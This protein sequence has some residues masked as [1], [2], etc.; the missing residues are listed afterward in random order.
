MMAQWQSCKTQ[1]KD[2][3]L[4]FR[5]G[6][7]YEAFYDDAKLISKQLGLT[8]T[9][10]QGVPM[11]GVPF[12]AHEQYVDK[13]I[14][15]GYKIAIAEQTEDPK[16]AKG[17][18]KREISR[19]CSPGTIVNSQLLNEK[20]NNYIAAISQIGS[21][22]GLAFLDLTTGD[23]RA[24]EL[25]QEAALIDELHRLR[26]AEFI[27]SRKFKERH[28]HFFQELSFTF[29]FLL[30]E[31]EE[32]QFD[33][34][35]A[36]Q[37]LL[38]HFQVSSLDGFGMKGLNAAITAAGSLLTYLKDD[39]SL[40]LNHIT[41]IQNEALSQFMAID[42]STMRNLELTESLSD[43]SSNN[44]LLDLIDHTATPM[45][46]RLI[47]QWLKHP[48]LNLSEIE[49]RQ[50]AVA[51][52]IVHPDAVQRVHQMLDRVRDLE[53]L[54]A[55]VVARYASPRDL[56]T[57]GHSLTVI[58][59]IRQ[60]L[61]NLPS[62]LIQSDLSYLHDVSAIAQEIGSSLND[63]PPLRISD[64]DIFRSG[65]YP[66]LD[67]LRGLSKDGVDWMARYQ[68]ELRERTGIKTLKVGYTK[69]FGYYIEVS[70]AKGEGIPE[71]FQRSQTLVNAER[72][73]TE[74]LKQ[75]EHQVLT[76]DERSKALE[77]SLFEELRSKTARESDS[78]LTIAK[79]LARI[80]ALLSLALAARE[81]RFNRPLVDE[82][83]LLE[84]TN[85]RHPVLERAIGASHFIPNDTH[86]DTPSQQ[87][88]LLTGPNMA[89]KS[90]YIRQ[91]ALIAILAQMGS[92]VP[93][94]SA[95]IGLIDRLFSRIGASDDLARGQST[96]MVEMSETA[97]ILHNAT[98][99]SLI[100]L[101]EIGRG[102]STYDGISIAWAVAEFLLT[103]TGK[104]AKTLFATH[105]W[106]LTRLETEHQGA[107]N[108]HV[109]VQETGNGIVF[110]RKIIPGGTDRSYGIHV[111]KLAGMPFAVLK[112][113]EE[114]LAKLEEVR[115]DQD[116]LP[117]KKRKMD[118]QLPL[119]ESPIIEE[120]R[121]IN[122]N[123][124]TPMQAL[125]I[126]SDLQARSVALCGKIN[127]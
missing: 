39:L 102:T 125:Q 107:I 127:Y 21:M 1:A 46:A 117:T 8:L 105:Y 38:S 98:S 24:L 66:E 86:L 20:K 3:L 6:D 29:S 101:D 40:R 56:W 80:D 26:P 36:L 34:S 119:F 9:Q 126:L 72:Y 110:L 42:R 32:W 54:I 7:F 120:L 104:R 95:H 112:R 109:A 19:I 93:A 70:R 67:H 62:A 118:P 81:H 90:T 18:V 103:T 11:C 68:A 123:Q 5:L 124:L 121:R 17:L 50:S 2:A 47:R 4:L 122:P 108:M 71:G 83:N 33:S 31:R 89:G 41:S 78:I 92:F 99:R 69:A 96:F 15:K 73:V 77:A 60:E 87:L 25:E 43:A 88:I 48:L 28:P 12:H 53:R 61:Q 63:T 116:T 79:A 14:A 44:T 64:G 114:M 115:Q 23:F 49:A 59:S 51:E 100:I 75:Y 58:P 55:K 16:N 91:V 94:D 30:S 57:L 37:T 27:A 111:A 22:F 35:N 82:S 10:R 113:S 106:E 13:L 74:E 45:G 76:A 97:N 65:V 52:W 84:I 85:G